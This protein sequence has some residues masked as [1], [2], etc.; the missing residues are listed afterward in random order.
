MARTA[1]PLTGEIRARTFELKEQGLGL[2]AIKKQLDAE[3]EKGT[4]ASPATIRRELEEAGYSFK[5][6]RNG[7]GNGN[8]KK[9]AEPSPEIPEPEVEEKQEE[10]PEPQV[11][12]STQEP[13]AEPAKEQEQELEQPITE[14]AEQSPED[15]Y[16]PLAL[17]LRPN[18][19]KDF[20]YNEPTVLILQKM[21]QTN[22]LPNGIMFSGIRGI[23]KT[24]AAR[25][26][27]RTLNCEQYPTREACGVCENCR[28]ALAGKHPDI[29]EID[30]ASHGNIEDIRRI[31]EE[32]TLAPY[33]G[34]KK[35]FIIDEAH[36]LGRSQASWDALLKILEEPPP[37]IMWIFCTTQ[38]HK[39]PDVI[40]SRLVSFDLRGIPTRLLS[41]YLSNILSSIGIHD[42]ADVCDIIARNAKNSIR[43]ALTFLE[44][45]MP[46][47]DE[48][49]WTKDNINYILNIM[50]FE[51]IRNIMECLLSKNLPA[52]WSIFERLLDDGM[53]AETI[54]NE[55]IFK[56]VDALADR[57]L[58]A[59]TDHQEEY[60]TFLSYYGCQ[61]V[62]HLADVVIQRSA[63]FTKTSNKRLVLQTIAMDMMGA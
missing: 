55:G 18:Y 51:D 7:N 58:G 44:K 40:K 36:N 32:A 30:G 29:R 6:G 54:F 23:G 41:D 31:L 26:F 5:K 47:C 45:V 43:D 21:L 52:L 22:K 19:F 57:S 24:S 25:I 35:V 59:P 28:A 38:K 3:F 33:M 39:I 13:A 20:I 16:V 10:Q 46:Y 9:K 61:R 49:G 50:D 14:P 15:K 62:K 56:M 34:R 60:D 63:D 53:D 2:N 12:E 27:A 8:G 11:D 1:I 4:V 42:A 17:Q 48:N 37:H